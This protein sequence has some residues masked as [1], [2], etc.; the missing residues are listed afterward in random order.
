MHSQ[1]ITSGLQFLRAQQYPDGSFCVYIS[2]D[3]AMQG[4]CTPDASLFPTALIANS[5]LSLRDHDTA[6]MVMPAA[7]F[8]RTQMARGGTWGHFARHHKWWAVCPMDADDTSCI[9]DL[10][11]R[12]AI[13]FPEQRNRQLLRHN[14][15]QAGLFYTWFTPRLRWNPDKDYWLLGL[16]ELKHPLTTL[17]FW[18]RMECSRRDV[19]AVVNANIL[20]YLGDVPETQAAIHWLIQLIREEREHDCDKWY[21]NVF[22][23]YYFI[24]RNLHRGIAA[25]EPVRQPIIDRIHA[26]AKPDGRIGETV[27]DTALAACTLQYL[28]DEGPQRSA[29]LQYLVSAQQPD[30]SWPR[31]RFYYG[32]P[33]KLTGYG[34]EE[35]TTAICLEALGGNRE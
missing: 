32:G 29:A 22:S 30:G 26:Q 2:G 35:L 8:L 27:L 31:Y 9:S 17:W 21:R 4:W 33:K 16:R 14:R 11:R 12:C 20:F 13:D 25:L 34:S 23:V 18:S 28:G 6:S 1:A 24:A 15:D 5:L 10:L 19:D 3:D 7:R